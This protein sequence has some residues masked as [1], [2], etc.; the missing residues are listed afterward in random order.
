[1]CSF[2]TNNFDFLTHVNA[3][4]ILMG[5]NINM[6]NTMLIH[7]AVYHTANGTSHLTAQ[8]NSIS[9]SD[10]FAEGMT[11]IGMYGNLRVFLCD[12]MNKVGDVY[13]TVLCGPGAL[14]LDY[15]LRDSVEVFPRA[16]TAGGTS[17]VGLRLAVSPGIK[18]VSYTGTEPT[19][20]TGATDANLALATNY[21]KVTGASVAEIPIVCIKTLA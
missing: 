9:A 8:A 5:E 11:F 6:F 14:R 4:N 12:R 16:T 7:S 3:A 21:T 10:Q 18:N 1:M 2:D 17:R 15:Q 13:D 20:L 19:A